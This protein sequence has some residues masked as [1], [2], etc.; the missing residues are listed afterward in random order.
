VAIGVV[1]AALG[2]AGF[3]YNGSAGVEDWPLK[4]D[5]VGYYAYLPALLTDG[6]WTFEDF[7]GARWERLE[8]SGFAGFPRHETTGRRQNLYTPGVALLQAPFFAV[9]HVI[10]SLTG[11]S[12][13]GLSWPYRLLACLGGA[14]YAVLGLTL[15]A[16]TLRR[17]FLEWVAATTVVALGLGTNLLYYGTIEP[18][19]SHAYSF[20]AFAAVV[21][22]TLAWA[23]SGRSWHALMLGA[24]LGL[25][26]LIRPTN[27]VLASFPLLFL[28]TRN[29]STGL[30]W[31]SSRD[32]RRV[33]VHVLLATA[34]AV[35]VT[36]PLFLYW[37]FVSGS[38]IHN[39]H[40][41]GTFFFTEPALGSVLWSYRKGWL[42][43]TPLMVGAIGGLVVVGRYVRGIT[44]PLVTFAVVNLYVVASWWNW[45]YGGGFGMRA[46]IESSAPLALSLAAFIAWAGS[47]SIRRRGV[48]GVVA[49]LAALNIFQTYQYVMT[50]IR[51]DGMTRETYWAVFLRPHIPEEELAVIRRDLDLDFP[52]SPRAATTSTPPR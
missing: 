6:G 13:D 42:V 25:V 20:C 33:V 3:A 15:V 30:R 49:I 27:A 45:W 48:W 31:S 32:R 1:Y 36:L 51:W 47:T 10:A 41:G 46:L 19:M 17:K 12:R 40:G 34:A 16:A 37:R 2:V 24:C 43:Y 44:L 4:Q 21:W 29:Q 35:V 11:A 39:P 38:W 9:G 23:E 28:F 14:A 8:A 18:L 26:V 50:Y 22:A 7:V 52:R 5:Q